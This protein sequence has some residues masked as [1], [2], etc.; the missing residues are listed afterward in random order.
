M[1]RFIIF[2]SLAV[3]A[4]ADSNSTNPVIQ[5]LNEKYQKAD[6]NKPLDIKDNFGIVIHA[7]DCSLDLATQKD[8]FADFKSDHECGDLC[9]QRPWQK[10]CPINKTVHTHKTKQYIKLT[11]Y[12]LR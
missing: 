6:Y 1:S 8:G 12:V 2:A 5:R 10:G 7:F 11:N 3:P 9:S 4:H